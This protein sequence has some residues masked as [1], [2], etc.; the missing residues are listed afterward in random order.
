M[1][2][3]DSL[4]TLGG[5]DMTG[6]NAVNKAVAVLVSLMMVATMVALGPAAGA[7][8]ADGAVAP[9]ATLTELG[10][11]TRTVI[12]NGRCGADAP[13]VGAQDVNQDVPFQVNSPTSV[14]PGTQFT[15]DF[16]ADPVPIPADLADLATINN[17]RNIELLNL[18]SQGVDVVSVEAVPGTGSF[19]NT[20]GATVAIPGTVTA[21]WDPNTRKVRTLLSGPFPGGSEVA[22]PTVR[23]TV[24]ATGASG[25]VVTT[26]LAG[27]IPANTAAFP[28]PDFG[29]AL[30]A[31]ATVAIITADVPT[32]CA[33]NY[34]P[35]SDILANRPLQ[36]P[37][38]SRTVIDGEGPE[39][40]LRSPQ[41]GAT[42]D[43]EAGPIVD[44]DC[45]DPSGVV[46]CV[47][48][49]EDGN[50][51]FKGDKLPDDQS[52][53]GELTLRAT[54][55]FG[56]TSERTITYRISG[57]SRPL[58]EVGDDIEAAT[59]KR[60]TLSGSAT[61]PDFG[62]LLSYTW[63]Q[64]SGPIVELTD[65]DDPFATSNT[66]ITPA[67]PAEL[68][69]VLRV[70]D[71][72]AY[73]EDTLTVF[74][75]P[76]NAPVITNGQDQVISGIET[77]GAVT[78]DATATDA[79][80][81]EVFYTW[82]QVD[83]DGDVLAED[84][85]ER[86]VLSDPNAPVVTFTAP[87]ISDALTLR[88]EVLVT[89]GDPRAE[90]IGTVT[91]NVEPNQVPVFGKG[92]AQIV[93]G[94]SGSLFT[95]DGTAVDPEGKPVTYTWTQ[96][97]SDGNVLEPGDPDFAVLSPSNTDP[98]VTFTAPE[99]PDPIT[100]R[101]R[102]VA[103]DGYALGGDAFGTVTV[104]IAAN[105]PPE[106]VNG[107]EQLIDSVQTRGE[108]TLDGTAVDPEG[109]P[110]T[111]SWTQ[112]D[113]EGVEL[114]NDDPTRVTLSATDEATATFTGLDTSTAYTLYFQVTVSDGIERGVTVGDVRVNFRAN[115][116]PEFTA[117]TTATAPAGVVVTLDG[118]ATD[119]DIIAGDDQTLVYAWV[120]VDANGD[121][122]PSSDPDFV[123]LVDPTTANPT[124]QSQFRVDPYTLYFRVTATDGY[125]D[126]TQT[127]TLSMTG[128]LA[129]IANA[130]ED[131]QVA[132]GVVVTLDSSA[133]SDP[134]DHDLIGFQWTQVDANG[135]PLAENDPA[136]VVLSDPTAA[137][138]TFTAPTT[139]TTL[140]FSLLVTDEYGAV[141]E[142]ADTV[143]IIIANRAP[144]ADAGGDKVGQAANS[145]VA[146][147]GVA[148]DPDVPL[149]I[150]VLW[151]QVDINGDVIV[152]PGTIDATDG[153]I[154]FADATSAVT[155]FITP[156]LSSATTLYLRMTVTDEL[157][158]TDSD[159]ISVGVNP[160][161]VG[162]PSS[163][164]APGTAGTNANAGT[165]IQLSVP[166][167]GAPNNPS[168]NFTYTWIQTN[169]VGSSV[170][171]Q[172]AG[173]CPQGVNVEFITT[174]TPG[175][176]TASTREPVI[177]LPGRYDGNPGAWTFRATVTDTFGG[178]TLT[179]A[180]LS[181]TVNNTNPTVRWSVRGF[182]SP[183][184]NATSDAN[185]ARNAVW[186]SSGANTDQSNSV[187]ELSAAL[188]AADQ[189][190]L[191]L[192]RD[193]LTCRWEAWTAST[194]RDSGNIFNPANQSNIIRTSPTGG[195][196]T[197]VNTTGRESC[198]PV[199]VTAIG[200]ESRY[201]RL[202]VTSAGYSSGAIN[203]A[204]SNSV[205]ENASPTATL[206][207]PA[208]ETVTAGIGQSY[209]A[210]VALNGTGYDANAISGAGQ[211]GGFSNGNWMTNGNTSAGANNV[212]QLPSQTITY[213]WRQVDGPTGTTALPDG[214][215]DKVVINDASGTLASA[216]SNRMT[217]N[218]P[219]PANTTFVPPE[220][221]KTV[222]FR[223][224][225]ADGLKTTL[226]AT[227][228]VTF[229]TNTSAPTADAGPDQDGIRTGQTVTLDSSGSFDEDGTIDSRLWEQVDSAGD[230]ITPTVS[231]TGDGAV[232]PTFVAP[233]V[234]V[235]TDL[236][237]K[238]TVTDNL[239]DTG[240]DIVRIG[241]LRDEFPT[242]VAGGDPVSAKAGETVTLS[243]DGSADPE[244]LTLSY[245][246]EQV[247]GDGNALL[248]LDPD[249]VTL[250]GSTTPTATFS[251]PGNPA[252]STLQFKLSVSDP[253]KQTA[254]ALVTINVAA[255]GAPV[256]VATSEPAV[257]GD[258]VTLD[259]TA[260]TDPEDGVL[261]FAWVQV[262]AD[263]DPLATDDPDYVT[264]TG[265]NTASA[266]F[267]A[268]GLTTASTLRFVL[269]VSD[270]FGVT[271]TAVLV[272][273]IPANGAPTAATSA[274]PDPA[275]AGESVTLSG[276]ESTDPENKPLTYAWVQVDANG[277]PVDES[278]STY[279]TLT[280]A[281]TVTASFEAPAN[282]DASVLRFRLTVTDQFGLTDSAIES[283]D[284]NADLPPIAAGTADPASAGPSAPVTL[285]AAGSTDPENKPLSYAWV[286]IDAD[287]DPLGESD[288]TYVTL[289]GANTVTATFDAPNLAVAS[290]LRFRL[291]VS[292]PFLAT[293][294]IIVTVEVAANQ[295]PTA[296]ASSMPF[297][298]A[299]GATVTLDASGSTDPESRPLT[300]LWE[301]TDLA[302]DALTDGDPDLVT[303]SS[304]TDASVTFTAP[305]QDTPP[306]RYFKVTVSDDINN[307]STALVSVSV[308]P[309]QAPVA[310][311]T[312]TSGLAPPE[313]VV[314]LDGS[315]SSDPE[316][317]DLT[318]QWTQTSGT[319]VVLTGAT[320]AAV[321][322][323]APV[324]EGE[325]LQFE[326]V[327]TDIWG[328]PSA[329]KMVAVALQAN[330]KPLA[331]AGG[332]QIDRR[333]GQT[334]TLDGSGS[335][336]PDG[337][338]F[339]YAW[340]QIDSGTLLPVTGGVVLNDATAE[341]P[342]FLATA[343]EQLLFRLVVTDQYGFE[344]N[345]SFTLVF[346]EPNRDPVPDAGADQTDLV[347]DTTATLAGSATDPDIDEGADQTLSYLWTQVSGTP[348]TLIDDTA[349][350]AT[351]TVPALLT[352]ED[353]VFRLT[354]TD[355]YSGSASDDVTIGVQ[356][357]RN[358]VVDAGSDQSGLAA[359]AEVD[360]SGS[361]TDA[362]IDDGANQ[363]LS[364]LW[365]QVSG[366]SV[367]L[368]GDTSTTPSFNA[369]STP[370][371]QDL[372]FR[373]TV[374]DGSGGV[375][376]ADVTVSVEANRLP[377]SDAGADQSDIQ[378][379]TLV[380]L[381]GSGS[382]D[383]DPQTITYL[384]EQTAG[385]TVTL[386]STTAVSPTF[387]TPI[388]P[389]AQTLTFEL[390]INDGGGGITTDSVNIGVLANRPPV[391][392]AS[393]DQLG[394]PGGDL[395]TLDGSASSDPDGQ[396][397]TFAWTQTA[398]FP[399]TLS[400]AT[401]EKPTFTA[402]ISVL[403][404]S[405]QF[406]LVVTDTLGL[407]STPD[408]VN[409][410]VSNN[411]AP[412]ADAGPDQ[413]VPRGRTVTLDGSGS[414]DPND[415][416]ITYQW[417]QT[418]GTTLNLL[419]PSDPFFATLTGATT[420]KPTFTAPAVTE[421]TDIYFVLVVTDP[422]GLASPPAWTKV[423]LGLNKPPVANAGPDQ[424][425]RTANST[426]TLTAA[427]TID[428]DAGEVLTYEW[429]QVD[430]DGNAIEPTSDVTDIAVELATPT[431]VTTTFVTPIINEPV[432]LR[433]KV[434]VTDSEGAFS[435]AFVNIGV[436]AN[437]APVIGSGTV[438]PAVGARVV[439]A[440][441][442]LT[443]PLP[444]VNADPDG[445]SRDLFTYQ[446]YRT[447]GPTSTEPCGD[448]CPGLPATLVDA[449]TRIATFT[450]P[451]V[452]IPDPTMYFRVAVDDGF[453]GVAISA[454]V[455]VQLTNSPVTINRN[456]I[457]VSTGAD[458]SVARTVSGGPAVN[459]SNSFLSGNFPATTYVY[460]GLPVMLDA[461][462]AAVDPDG[463]EVR[464]RFQSGLLPVVTG[465]LNQ[466]SQ[467]PNGVCSGGFLLFESE[468]PNVWIFIPPTGITQVNAYCRIQFQAS[469]SAGFTTTWGTPAICVTGFIDDLA[470]AIA[471]E[472]VC[473]SNPTGQ[474]HT[475]G[476]GQGASQRAANVSNNLAADFWFQIVQNQANPIARVGE[477][478]ARVFNSSVGAG[479]TVVPVDGSASSDA[480]SNPVQP[481]VYKWTDI[482][483]VTREP[484]PDPDPADD[485]LSDRT[486]PDAQFTAPNG[487]P[488]LHRFQLEVSDGIETD[489]VETTTL[490][491]TTRRPVVAGSAVLPP[492]DEEPG[493]L[494][495]ARPSTIPNDDV[496]AVV[497][498][499]VV[500]LTGAGSMSPDGRS[501]EYEWR[502]IA[503]PTAEI[504][505]AFDE[506]ALVTVGN[507]SSGNTEDLVIELA[508]R[509]GFSAA[510]KTFTFANEYLEPEPDAFC[511]FDSTNPFNDVSYNPQV[512]AATGCLVEQ[513]VLRAATS[514]N[515]FNTLTRGAQLLILHRLEGTPG[516]Y[517]A[518][519]QGIFIDIPATGELR[520]AIEWAYAEGVTTPAARYNPGN[521]V[522]RQQMV[523]FLH[524]LAGSPV[525]LAPSGFTD[526][527]QS[528]AE[529]R[530]A[531]AWGVEVGVVT[532]PS[533]NNPRFNPLS[534]M[535]RG[536]MSLFVWRFGH[537]MSMWNIDPDILAMPPR[538]V[539]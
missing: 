4:G 33:P 322:F 1:L 397:I 382:S 230:P 421:D 315:P 198:A 537:A 157:G 50:E 172:T 378:P 412:I 213:E 347:A 140:Y 113:A 498:G 251:A 466:T 199:Y 55:G 21:T 159:T 52:R 467:N 479:E 443:L 471:G 463:G 332:A 196:N 87:D 261:S 531:V 121:P 485:P 180:N 314:T 83:E 153:F 6:T 539:G 235:D 298:P 250:T 403:G 238:V 119:A 503:G 161:V 468:I 373:L 256:A 517:P 187:Y 197:K 529:V 260:S 309:N 20:S 379:N 303:L 301:Q 129:P 409:I 285:S 459:T 179:S 212:Q 164:V 483:P 328:K 16:I 209:P 500:E 413:N 386:S 184:M 173:N 103:N 519:P 368:T 425:G 221:N 94:P 501:L 362:D 472:P 69:F 312:S 12:T 428:P 123:T 169:G 275:A 108:V 480:D 390:T 232:R 340:A 263:D 450:V 486:S 54:D 518:V 131:Q 294:S 106:I 408:L 118:T 453:G 2:T 139:P 279:V 333:P 538:Q 19:I 439:N 124:F 410:I 176:F 370:N 448:A 436:L 141:S 136:L 431:A 346:V 268:P 381:D 145:T 25:A 456:N 469:D 508:I 185:G 429:T 521:P 290:T 195:T 81:Q 494:P 116:L 56:F 515:P 201:F 14:L 247:D 190:T 182:G 243:A 146:L 511:P 115:V 331:S 234:A 476:R 465:L 452:T 208:S 455:T 374:S 344:S 37:F 282:V 424:T 46:E 76:N 162:A 92:P 53:Q 337:H 36:T 385:T 497:R 240:S 398:G 339:T 181:L 100:Y 175:G 205:N 533:G 449:D 304:T 345:P 399:V 509:D 183:A 210:T 291:T 224:A 507:P 330:N 7:Q 70:D 280:G 308:L 134:D 262:D 527:S 470:A 222:Y 526:L 22:P 216:P 43:V 535:Q 534:P 355:S 295:A 416:P 85:P 447:A 93:P 267:S 147:D 73:G 444:G 11:E 253:A 270:P 336:D 204:V 441:V 168:N 329:P 163:A 225:V 297:E 358:P 27:T 348:V 512:F 133:S 38:L 97:D 411:V 375:G 167:P 415:D 353:L 360:L 236:F 437:R 218:T 525:A 152:G 349:T 307:T 380:T 376:T 202:T 504:D 23:A 138:P 226:S 156:Q 28:W 101:F 394:V 488:S 513:D 86:V 105:V 435:E 422:S 248:P 351:F 458:F 484:L 10:R 499:D 271:D 536:Q 32:Y 127:I 171:C 311:V 241:V 200:N 464:V 160:I 367:T 383:A 144:T 151:E 520:N 150:T 377:V 192:D 324:T 514:F 68:V 423:T 293:D 265:A 365:T 325:I 359:N 326:L 72:V 317:S 188:N 461:R 95:L 487:G 387:T 392:N 258:T 80:D 78:M 350:T 143:A 432:T 174:G 489:V 352:A 502:Q 237:F 125:D 110:V 193:L 15:I 475:G 104:E 41:N 254:S 120:Q 323:T 34:G 42:Y 281:T 528:S 319:T 434:L 407:S 454:N 89:D 245:L 102:V 310:S 481:L 99:T 316:G 302:G 388:T 5:N 207:S 442:T 135:A 460:G 418:E 363:A 58:V 473:G 9:A 128:N 75:D 305:G 361:A 154:E 420:V 445:T 62:Q 440:T 289:T 244:N 63:I 321:S 219:V 26:Q 277:D 296:S 524:R 48:T 40:R 342:T 249:L 35:R 142:A 257:A 400:D 389:A 64:Q 482:D 214:H 165:F 158:L 402:P 419:S 177:E 532:P 229:F 530:D 313:A 335:S 98:I 74:V 457:V 67:G 220:G 284:I 166:Q 522:N 255:N 71:G 170:D 495:T 286:Q 109:R 369:P 203:F 274:T 496:G 231:I 223:L 122:L 426:V 24:V 493:A 82:T 66:F 510:Y 60:V 44:F 30:T 259:G 391:A 264:L 523:L 384:W 327:V 45:V 430:A 299:A 47:M 357:N 132:R 269:T 446:W 242:A 88:F 404:A 395:V 516:G 252:A 189:P 283:V 366:T 341:K 239:G 77:R 414:F 51:V 178:A 206:T 364:Y 491:V 90:V 246:W 492:V 61:D 31:N 451:G 506:T 343:P 29:F 320:S 462:N 194:R 117:S 406:R 39:L 278:D 405:L 79:D 148:T 215:P 396:D 427:G 112:V 191:N 338:T 228:A 287:D 288:S 96:V 137:N 217:L 474:F 477:L 8:E 356:A 276:A 372:V 84:D 126:V 107:S 114:A 59:N 371:A 130:G 211:P 227:R 111:Y 65:S 318:F 401:A 272:V 393:D 155:S 57:N 17:I 3:L 292:D 505:G 233:S 478:P 334:V 186:R 354:V 18:V 91:V 417:L 490:K 306:V 273:V 266:T 149:D 49:D 13:V 438:A 300:F 433:F